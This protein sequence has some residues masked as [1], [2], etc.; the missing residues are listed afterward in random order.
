MEVRNL[1]R[2]TSLGDRIR[3]ATSLWQNVRGLM[4]TPPLGEGEGLI[5]DMGGETRLG[6]WMPLMRYALDV[7]YADERFTV[8]GLA[9]DI[10]PMGLNPRTW[11]VYYPQKPARYA[12]EV[13]VGTIERTGIE[14]GDTLVF[15]D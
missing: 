1:T 6:I 8:T 3:H 2:E 4:L 5:I 7:V 13:P 10:P 14:L 9:R 11:R 15:E 12:V